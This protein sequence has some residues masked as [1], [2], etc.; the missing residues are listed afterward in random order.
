M[1][2]AGTVRAVKV[3]FTSEWAILKRHP[4]ILDAAL[5]WLR[6]VRLDD[7]NYWLDYYRILNKTNPALAKQLLLEATERITGYHFDPPEDINVSMARYGLASSNPA[8]SHEIQHMD[9]QTIF[10]FTSPKG[11]ADRTGLFKVYERLNG[12]WE[13][14]STYL[15]ETKF[16]KPV[17]VC[18]TADIPFDPC[19]DVEIKVKVGRTMGAE[20]VKKYNLPFHITGKIPE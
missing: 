6:T 7:D 12:A 2:L 17:S 15:A 1:S 3:I 4:K 5:T 16:G 8:A 20:L 14:S 9:H 11:G 18:I 19:T 13:T 10:D